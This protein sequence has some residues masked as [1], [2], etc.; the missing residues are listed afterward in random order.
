MMWSNVSY[1]GG[2]YRV[3]RSVVKPN[4]RYTNSVKIGSSDSKR[5][6]VLTFTK[7]NLW[8]SHWQV[9][10]WLVLN[11]YD[12]LSCFLHDFASGKCEKCI[13]DSKQEDDRC[14]LYLETSNSTFLKTYFWQMVKQIFHLTPSQTI[15][16]LWIV[17]STTNTLW[18][19]MDPLNHTLLTLFDRL[20]VIYSS[21]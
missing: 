8:L 3:Y 19:L 2:G 13:D 4:N 17:V 6:H 16:T 20:L 14:T 9:T 7:C 21:F 12:G 1:T 10:V 18:F 15:M 5:P 11:Y